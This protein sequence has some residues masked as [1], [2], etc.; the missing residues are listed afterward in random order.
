MLKLRKLHGVRD[1]PEPLYPV[2]KCVRECLPD[3]VISPIHVAV[4]DRAV[5]GLEQPV[6]HL[7][8]AADLLGPVN[9]TPA[10]VRLVML[11]WFAVQ[12]AAL[13]GVPFLLLDDGDTDEF[14]QLVDY[15]RRIKD[16]LQ[17]SGQPPSAPDRQRFNEDFI[18]TL[19]GTI[20]NII[21]PFPPREPWTVAQRW[22]RVIQ[23]LLT[24]FPWDQADD[25]ATIILNGLLDL[26]NYEDGDALD[27]AI[28]EG[29]GK[30]AWYRDQG[31]RE[32]SSFL[33]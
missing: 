12:E 27:A 33:K 21:Y 14:R 10:D 26:S 23:E 19:H 24:C 31:T 28:A 17:S 29:L 1:Q 18:E 25:I 3:D 15:L 16:D 2:R 30:G 9:A 7:A 8:T 13:A 32:E 6:I 5:G 22:T 20:R 11:D 4:E